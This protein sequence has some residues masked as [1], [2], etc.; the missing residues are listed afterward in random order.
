MLDAEKLTVK[1]CEGELQ[2][3]QAS[4]LVVGTWQRKGVGWMRVIFDLLDVCFGE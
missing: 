2:H 4:A 3:V 1:K